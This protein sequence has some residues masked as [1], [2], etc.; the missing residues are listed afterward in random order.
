MML[1]VF[2]GDAFSFTNLVA[3]INRIPFVPTRI[4]RMGLFSSEGVNTTSVAVE[5]QAGVLTLVPAAPRGSRGP[6]KNVEKRTVRD[7]RTVHLPQS[8]EVMADEVQGI[9]VFG[10]ESET[11]TAMA[12]L[13]KKMAVAR[14]DLDL[15]HEWQRIGALKGVVLDA[16]GVTVIYNYFT[17]FGLAQ[18]TQNFAFSVDATKVR[19]VCNA[20]ARKIEDKLGGLMMVGGIHAFVGKTFFDALIDHP[21]VRDTYLGSG[22]SSELRRGLRMNFEFGDIV[23]EEYRGSVGGNAF[24][25]DDEGYAFPLGVPELFKTFYAPAPYMDTAGTNGLPFY[26]KGRAMDFDKGLDYEVQSNPLHMNTRPE[27]VVKLTMS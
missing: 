15:T 25:A 1:D 21:A 11:E 23:F 3:A 6:S 17:E 9:R 13:Q 7:F 12:L 24:V 8:V 26:M 19:G 14:R 20:V 5:M 22:Q 2:K 10:S 16:D 27:A 18:Q 4:G